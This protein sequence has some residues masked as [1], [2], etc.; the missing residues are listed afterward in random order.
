MYVV[1]MAI[2]FAFMHCVSFAFQS[3]HRRLFR[4]LTWM[5]DCS[6]QEGQGVTRTKRYTSF[7]LLAVL[8][9]V[10]WCR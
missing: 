9:R 5:D 8:Y 4:V 2:S 7:R 6:E 10:Y 1:S 3:F